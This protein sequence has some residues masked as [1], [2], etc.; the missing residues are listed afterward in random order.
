MYL[1]RLCL[2]SRGLFIRYQNINERKSHEESIGNHIGSGGY[3]GVFTPGGRLFLHLQ[4]WLGQ[5]LQG[6][7][8][9]QVLQ[10]RGPRRCTGRKSP[11]TGPRRCSGSSGREVTDVPSSQEAPSDGRGFFFYPSAVCLSQRLQAPCLIACRKSALMSSIFSRPTAT[12]MNSGVT[13]A[14]R[15]AASVICL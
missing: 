15:W 10:S 9:R 13:P 1:S 2:I 4:G 12:R 11:G 8:H 3:G 5:V 6:S 7:R 14:A